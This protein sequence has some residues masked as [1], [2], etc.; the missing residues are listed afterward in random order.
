M[1]NSESKN[2][3]LALQK[4]KFFSLKTQNPTQTKLSEVFSFLDQNKFTEAFLA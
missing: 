4:F 2:R 3:L 1:S